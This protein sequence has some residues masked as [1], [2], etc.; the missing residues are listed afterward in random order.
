MNSTPDS[1]S[2]D[3]SPSWFGV[4]VAGV[5]GIVGIATAVSSFSL[6]LWTRL[7]PGPGFFPLILGFLLCAGGVFWGREQWKGLVEED[8][9][10]GEERNG[11][12]RILSIGGSI[13]IAA[14]LLELLGFQIT[15]LL[16]LVFHL[17]ILHRVRWLIAVP[18]TLLGSFGTFV[19]FHVLLAVHL[20]TSSIPFLA[21]LGL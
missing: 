5:I 9:D 15:M 2:T 19:L 12:L 1:P 4:I 8:V 17:R 7:G 16:F 21:G 6:G 10:E 13:I 3:T 11:P 14:L 20:P 18:V